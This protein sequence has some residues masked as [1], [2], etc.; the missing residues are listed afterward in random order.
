MCALLGS[1]GYRGYFNRNYSM[2]PDFHCQVNIV[3][4]FQDIAAFAYCLELGALAP[5]VYANVIYWY[6]PEF[7]NMLP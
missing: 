3:F 2:Y 6:W 5:N 1:L 7:R 4:V